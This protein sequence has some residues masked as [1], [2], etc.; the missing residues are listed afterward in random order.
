MYCRNPWWAHEGRAAPNEISSVTDL[1]RP[2]AN[3]ATAPHTFLNPIISTGLTWFSNGNR[4]VEEAPGRTGRTLRLFENGASVCSF[5]FEIRM[6]RLRS[7]A[8]WFWISRSSCTVTLFRWIHRSLN[9][10]AHLWRSWIP[11]WI[12]NCAGKWG[13]LDG[14]GDVGVVGVSWV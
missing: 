2:Y 4:T 14:G 1:P 10:N 8:S 13:H 5:D 3:V 12:A 7:D 11:S 9:W 6:A